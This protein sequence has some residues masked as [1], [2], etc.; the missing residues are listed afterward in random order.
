MST[1]NL[2]RLAAELSTHAKVIQDHLEACNYAGLSLDTNAPIEVPLDLSNTEI[3]EAR[4]ALIKSS[5]LIHDLTSGPQD[6]LMDLTVNVF[7]Y[8][9]RKLSCFGLC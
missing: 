9:I 1:H 7:I 3:Q 4:A 2:S 8:L 5:K 6:L